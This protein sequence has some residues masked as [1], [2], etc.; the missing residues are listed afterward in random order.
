MKKNILVFPCGSEIGL[1]IHRS[2]KYSTHFN[3]IGGS[4]VDDH[5]KFIYENYIE[6]IPF[7]NSVNFLE[8]INKIVLDYTIDA[9]Y[10]TM[11]EV[12]RTF[13]NNEEAIECRVV[14]SSAETTAIC[15]SKKLTYKKLKDLIPI[16]KTYATLES[17]EEY[18]L[19]I[20]PD[21]GYGSRNVC[22]ANDETAAQEFLKGNLSEKEFVLCEFLP[23]AE[24][25]IDCFSNRHGNL[26]FVG[27]RKRVRI[28][29][30]ISVNTKQT[31]EHN[32]L[33]TSYADIIN[34]QLKPR[35]A[36]FFQM[37]L[38]KDDNLKLLE[39]AARL[40]GSSS[41][42]RSK[43]VNFAMLSTFD[44][45]DM[46]VEIMQNSYE[47]ELDRALSNRYMLKIEYTTVYV[48]YDDCILLGDKVN[49]EIIAYLYAILNQRIKIILITRHAGNIQQS[50]SKYRLQGLFDEVIHLTKKEKKS[51]YINPNGAIFIDDSHAER[52][53]VKK[54]YNIH[55][56]SPDMVETLF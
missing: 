30:G 44:C 52:A 7:H 28:S 15:N 19:F 17:A 14:G 48:D 24:Y 5:G 26:L 34:K 53:D 27:A 18:P 25:T 13:K 4:S 3:L 6:N 1:E 49:Q 40:G 41:L 37:K 50:L 36:W 39:I 46:D 9:I 38:D 45:F 23:G 43:G 35:G 31:N 11:D 33:F 56:F 20:K 54:K 42:F 12:A 10:P 47:A 29:N 55:V 32:A 16:P 2:L 51:D 8:T 22:L 21:V